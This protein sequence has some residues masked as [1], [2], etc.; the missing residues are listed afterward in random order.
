MPVPKTIG[1]PGRGVRV[2]AA[3]RRAALALASITVPE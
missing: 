3:R 1:A 2:P